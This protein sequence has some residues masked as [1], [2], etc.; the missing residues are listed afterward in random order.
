M[1]SKTHLGIGIATSLTVI[2][3]KSLEECLISVAGGALG[4]VL[5]DIDI[6]DNDY[7]SDALIGQ[8]I[9]TIIAILPV[10]ADYFCDFGICTYVLNNKVLSIA[11]GIVYF[12]LWIC[13]FCSEHRKFTHS[14]VA[15]I[16]YSMAFYLI[17]PPI[18]NGFV[19]AYLSH[20]GLDLLNKKKIQLF[21]P[22]KF[23]ICL[24]ICYASKLANTI[25]MYIGLIFSILLI[26]KCF[27]VF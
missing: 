11:G 8:T 17:Y 24:H 15:M 22:F 20:L 13:G 19:V 12:T 14:I 23:G 5:A 6:L 16:L 26:I 27:V 7:K 1:M 4:R 9:A 18:I 2:Q 21:F 25:F 3:P 10:L